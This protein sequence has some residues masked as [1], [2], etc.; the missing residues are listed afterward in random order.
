MRFMG[1]DVQVPRSR[2]GLREPFLAHGRRD[3][4]VLILVT[5]C[6]VRT[7]NATHFGDDNNE[8]EIRL[9]K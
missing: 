5:R 6:A 1:A 8:S 2:R 4:H 9:R 3:Q 7:G